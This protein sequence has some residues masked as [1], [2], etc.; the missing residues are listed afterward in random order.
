MTY[1]NSLNIK[2]WFASTGNIFSLPFLH[3]SIDIVYTS[4][5]IEPNGGKENL[6]LK[7]LYRVARN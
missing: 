4:H 3:N 6:L 2:N 1:L 7:E 5:S